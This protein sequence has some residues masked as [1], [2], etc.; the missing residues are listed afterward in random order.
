LDDVD[1][2]V[3]IFEL[4]QGAVHHVFL[5][6]EQA[7]LGFQGQAV[8]H[9]GGAD[10]L[11]VPDDFVEREGDLLLGLELDD[12]GDLAFFDGRQLHEPRQAALAGD[13]DDDH[14]SPQA[15]AR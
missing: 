2:D 9:H 4:R 8:G 3:D 10:A 7:D 14:V 15:V 12:V 11:V 1:F 5:H 13:A 6:G